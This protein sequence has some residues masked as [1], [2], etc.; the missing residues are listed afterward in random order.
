M[1]RIGANTVEPKRRYVCP[2]CQVELNRER[3]E[4]IRMDATLEGPGFEVTFQ[5]D[6]PAELGSYGARYDSR[7]VLQEGCRVKFGCP[8]CGRDFTSEYSSDWAELKMVE[9]GREF[10]V[11]FNKI[12]G[13]HSSFLFDYSTRRLVGTYGDATSDLI[14]QFGKNLNFFGS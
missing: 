13:E 6:I 9:A 3:P 7:I 5:I 8:Q 12:Y 11:V 14:E 1:G 4:L 2:F 10:V